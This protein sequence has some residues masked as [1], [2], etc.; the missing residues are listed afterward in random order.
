MAWNTSLFYKTTL[1]AVKGL[2]L[3]FKVWDFDKLWEKD[4][5]Y[6]FEKQIVLKSDQ[7]KAIWLLVSSKQTCLFFSNRRSYHHE[8]KGSELV[9]VEPQERVKSIRNSLTHLI[10]S[11]KIMLFQTDE[12]QKV[13]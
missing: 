11:L 1:I 2:L 13:I 10:S 9:S 12:S 4:Y 5:G 3:F 8:W 6:D 7:N